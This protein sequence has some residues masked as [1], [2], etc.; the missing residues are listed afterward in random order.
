MNNRII[1]GVVSLIV[2]ATTT[3]ALG[4]PLSDGGNTFGAPA[5]VGTND[6][7]DMRIRTNNA[8]RVVIKTDGRVGIGTNIP[9]ATLEVAGTVKFTGGAPGAG[10]VLTSDSVGLASWAVLPTDV[11][12]VNSANSY[13]SISNTTTTPVITANVGISANTLAAGND[14][15]IT[16][17]LQTSAYAADLAP[18]TSCAPSA[19]PSWNTIT[20]LWECISI[21]ALN[22]SVLSSG[23][24]DSARLGSGSASSTTFLRGDG[25]W[26]IP[27]PAINIATGTGLVGGPITSSGTISLANTAV[28]AGTYG[29]ATQVAQFTVDSQ[30]RIVSAGNVSIT[31]GGSSQWTTAGSDIY[32]PTG[33]VGIGTSSPTAKLHIENGDANIHGLTVG[34]GSGANSDSVA[35]GIGAL[36][37]NTSGSYNTAIGR[38]ALILNSTG[39]SN[40]AVGSGSAA[41]NQTGFLNSSFGLDSLANVSSGSKNVALG[42]GAMRSNT[43]GEQ[44][45]AVGYEALYSNTVA[46]HSVAIGEYALRDSAITVNFTSTHNTAVGYNAGRG[47]V[48]GVENT[49][50][51]ANVTGLSASLSNNI[52]IADGAGN[53]RINVVSNGDVGIGTNSPTTKLQVAGVISPSVDATHTLGSSSLRFYDI[54]SL[55]SNNNTSDVREKR[56]IQKSDLGLEFIL[57]LNPVSYRWKNGADSHLHYGLIAQETQKVLEQLVG[58]TGKSTIVT[59][60]KESD[61]YGMRYSELI[62]PIIKAVQDLNNQSLADKKEIATLKTLNANLEARL[63]ALEKAILSK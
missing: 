50:I 3:I 24:V 22:A 21:G 54:F 48:T 13:L 14:S 25:T 38:N 17:A 4:A 6:N 27:S 55:N 39:N 44:N 10:K 52:I 49:I 51:G 57:K 20:D 33:S 43:T 32:Y 9:G 63:Q 8:N 16:N 30:G 46:S 19:K 56:E 60:D 7:F 35:V 28:T 34:R 23:T 42:S 59:Y 53:R 45:T 29:S 58:P 40:T 61:R 62:S 1:I 5:S 41:S 15:R 37:F 18:V 11:T 26:A 36:S 2:H 47:I 31:G 12:S